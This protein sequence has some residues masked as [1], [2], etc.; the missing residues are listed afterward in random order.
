MRY[1]DLLDTYLPNGEL[2]D[3]IDRLLEIKTNSAESDTVERNAIIENWLNN[4]VPEL[5]KMIP[6]SPRVVDV[7]VFDGVFREVVGMV[8]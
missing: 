7:E 4:Q 8:G 1:H 2:R 6:K 3:E 5:E